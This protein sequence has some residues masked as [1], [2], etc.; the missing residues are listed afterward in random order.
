MAFV[1]VHM[2]EHG[3][4]FRPGTGNGVY[5]AY[6]HLSAARNAELD[7]FVGMLQL[8][9]G[10]FLHPMSAA[11]QPHALEIDCH[12]RVKVRRPH[13]RLYLFIERIGKS[14]RKFHNALF[15]D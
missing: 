13:L 2:L 10:L 3:L 12:R 15:Y 14:F 8:L 11:G 4:G 1:F 6:L 7:E 5:R 9:F